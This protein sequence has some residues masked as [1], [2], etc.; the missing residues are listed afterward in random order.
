MSRAK[1]TLRSSGGSQLAYQGMNNAKNYG[2]FQAM[3]DTLY[4]AEGYNLGNMIEN[5]SMTWSVHNPQRMS[6]EA[7]IGLGPH[8]F[9]IVAYPRDT[10]PYYL[11]TFGITEDQIVRVYKPENTAEGLNEFN[12]PDDP[13]VQT[14]DPAM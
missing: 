8:S 14:W 13:R 9:T 1:G 7:E 6:D 5:Y 12:G 11:M 10:R 4:I 2:S 3:K